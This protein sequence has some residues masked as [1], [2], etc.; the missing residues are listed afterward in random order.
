M[1]PIKKHNVVII[2]MESFAGNYV[3]ELGNKYN[4]TPNFDKLTKEGV[5]FTKMFSSG[6]RT[7]RGLSSTLLSFPGLPR[8]KSIL[9]DASV[10]QNFS[11]LA[12][13]LKKR[14]YETYFLVGGKLDYDNR[15][16]F[17]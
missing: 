6:T 1:K 10:D 5:L 15:H 17:F 11:S 3:G 16:G 9:N 4:I 7:N 12:N 8:F 2:L 13:I 14:D